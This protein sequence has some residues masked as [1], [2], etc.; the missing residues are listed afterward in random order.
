MPQTSKSWGGR[1]PG[2]RKRARESRPQ[3]T[4]GFVKKKTAA[5]AYKLVAR[6][7][8]AIRRAPLVELK[9]RTCEEVWSELG[10]G[11]IIP[12]PMLEAF[13]PHDNAITNITPL[14]TSYFIQGTKEDQMIGRSLY[15]RFLTQK[16]E[17]KFPQGAN[18]LSIPAEL[19]LVHGFVKTSPNFTGRTDPLARDA[20]YTDIRD[21]ITQQVGDYFDDRTDKLRYIP[22]KGSTLEILGYKKIV[23][24][25]QNQFSVPPTVTDYPSENVGAVP[26]MNMTIKWPMSVKVDVEQGAVLQQSDPDFHYVNVGQKV[27]FSIL[28]NPMWEDWTPVNNDQSIGVRSNGILYFTDS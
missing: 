26:L 2:Q 17:I 5:G 20:T 19:Y 23:P 21:R 12:N 14:A 16:I 15:A 9:T 24:K 8:M 22:K 4:K 3:S 18:L 13:V 28:Y 1:V 27:P 10:A 6:K 25:L 11:T 7:Q